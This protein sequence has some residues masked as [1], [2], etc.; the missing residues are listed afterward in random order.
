MECEIFNKRI[1]KKLVI[2]DYV[3]ELYATDGVPKGNYFF[4]KLDGLGEAQADR[5][6]MES[7]LDGAIYIRSTL[8]EREVTIELMMIPDET[9]SMESLRRELSQM[10]N[11]KAGILELTYLEDQMSYRIDAVSDHVPTF[12]T[13]DYLSEKGQRVTVTLIAPDPFWYGLEDEVHYLSN[14]VGNLEW[15]LEFPMSGNQ[16]SGIELEVFN[17]DGL[18]TLTNNGDEQ[19]GAIFTLVASSE[20]KNPNII[21][22]MS[23]GTAN[24]FIKLNTTMVAGDQIRIITMTGSKRVEKW[25]DKTQTWINAF[26]LIDLT[27]DFIQLDIGENYLRY[28]TESN[29][30]QLAIKVEYKL[31]YVGV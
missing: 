4:L 9:K 11:P 30:N 10:L 17:G 20:V 6:T 23:D 18:V 16:E 22:I 14:W 1:N 12:M 29:P 21:R 7:N 13:E 15:D 31:R 26:H 28:E 5:H 24:Q 25:Q 19:T 2:K 8:A 3:K 27:S